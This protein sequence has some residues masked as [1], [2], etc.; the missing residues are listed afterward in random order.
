[1]RNEAW[2]CAGPCRGD[3]V[4]KAVLTSGIRKSGSLAI[5]IFVAAAVALLRGALQAADRILLLWIYGRHR[6][7]TEH[8]TIV[9]TKPDIVVSNGDVLHGKGF[10]HYLLGISIWLITTIAFVLLAY[11]LLPRRERNAVSGRYTVSGTAVLII[12]ALFFAIGTLPL[13]LS[14]FLA[15]F[16]ITIGLLLP[17]VRDEIQRSR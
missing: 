17:W 8:L 3:W 12:I 7:L 10:E 6:V 5:I 15:V 13:G 2:P 14:L 16:V 9:K 4:T 11:R 1:M